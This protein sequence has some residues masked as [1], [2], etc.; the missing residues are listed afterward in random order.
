MFRR[1]EGIALA[2]LGRTLSV[3]LVGKDVEWAGTRSMD[4]FPGGSR[5]GGARAAGNRGFVA[6][7]PKAH[8]GPGTG[9]GVTAPMRYKELVNV[10]GAIARALCTKCS[11]HDD[12]R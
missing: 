8:D 9:G 7:S 10:T 1:L 4:A 6:T 12:G 11:C 3:L 5:A 2:L